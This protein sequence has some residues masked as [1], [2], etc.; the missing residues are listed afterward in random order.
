MRWC[1]VDV[2]LDIVAANVGHLVAS[3][4]PAR[5]WAVVKADGYGHGA[6]GVARA[7]LA[8]GASGLC[9][10][11]VAEGVRLREAGIDV[12]ILVLSEQPADAA[13]TIVAHDLSPTVYSEAAIR[14]LAAAAVAAGR[15]VGVHL[16]VD[17][18][19]RRVGA[20]PGDV[21][22]L[23]EFIAATDGVRLAGLSTHLAAADDPAH[24]ATALQLGVF[25]A[26]VDAVAPGPGVLVHVANSAA[27]IAHPST[28][29]DLVRT[30]IAI[31]GIDPSDMVRVPDGIRPALRW[32]AR[33]SL[34][35]S[36]PAGDHVSYGW[37]YR[38]EEPTRLATVPAGYADGVPRRYSAVGGEVLVNGRRRR[39]V[40]VVTM[41]QFVIDLGPESDGDTVVVGDEVVLIGAQGDEEIRAEEWADR[42]GTIGYEVVCAV[43][44]RVPRSFVGA[45]AERS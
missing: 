35:K 39:V 43:S 32:W 4:A 10:A 2:D 22:R 5:L 36:V 20:E 3:V 12:P 30:G 19:M 16:K 25:D 17:S 18:G 15:S 7:A 33:V 14:A 13:A 21:P 40:G 23:A 45:V 31:Y 9:V 8:G 11:L 37:R 27:A 38:V 44:A 41:D 24:P 34:V 26:V 1:G 29:R 42:L 6:V 28:R